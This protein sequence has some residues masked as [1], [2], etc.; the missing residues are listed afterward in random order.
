MY[1]LFFLLRIIIKNTMRVHLYANVRKKKFPYTCTQKCSPRA[2]RITTIRLPLYFQIILCKRNLP[3]N[4]FFFKINL[5]YRSL[6]SLSQ[7]IS[8]E[9]HG[10]ADAFVYKNFICKRN[11][12]SYFFLNFFFQI[13][14]LNLV[15]LF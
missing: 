13:I 11:F 9:K 5:P 15:Y 1:F 8:S 14:R 2:H 10:L 4:Y 12:P 3:K 6:K 7:R